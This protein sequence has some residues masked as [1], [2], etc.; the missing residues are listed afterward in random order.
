MQEAIL[1]DD[2]DIRNI[3]V[4]DLMSFGDLAYQG[5]SDARYTPPKWAKNQWRAIMSN[6]WNRDEE[7]SSSTETVISFAVF[8]KMLGK[9]LGHLTEDL[10][11]AFLKRYVTVVIGQ[12]AIYVRP[13][14]EEPSIPIHVFACDDVHK[15]MLTNPGHKAFFGTWKKGDDKK[16]PGFEEAV[17]REQAFLDVVRTAT[18][19]LT[20]EKDINEWWVTHIV[21]NHRT[22]TAPINVIPASPMEPSVLQV[23][24]GTDGSY[25]IPIPHIG[26][27]ATDRNRF[28]M[29][30]GYSSSS[31]GSV[32]GPSAPPNRATV[33]HDLCGSPSDQGELQRILA[34]K[35]SEAG[36]DGA[37]IDLCTPPRRKHSLVSFCG[38]SGDEDEAQH[39]FSA[40]AQTLDGD[41]F[42]VSSGVDSPPDKNPKKCESDSPGRRRFEDDMAKAIA[43]S[44]NTFSEAQ[45]GPS[46]PT[47]SHVLQDD[48]TLDA[49][50]LANAF[51]IESPENPLGHSYSLDHA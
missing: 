39:I 44:E 5:H 14:S 42:S 29:P 12:N 20:T 47:S 36:L 16:Y 45:S 31:S 11:L 25:H 3:S 33:V 9:S 7:P 32:E 30:P 49:Q 27:G 48:V 17:H 41:S 43:D 34:S 4:L 23:P 51:G 35:I 26:S 40:L 24:F 37:C 50:D 2:P 8:Q 38:E 13:P 28:V 46:R 18:C 15:D 1:L 19:D 10:R 6:A 22:S 21:Q